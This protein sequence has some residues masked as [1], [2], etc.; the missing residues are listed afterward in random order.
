MAFEPKEWQCGNVLSAEDMNRLEEGV[1]AVTPLIVSAGYDGAG[2]Q[3]SRTWK[4]IND[5]FP[6][7]YIVFDN[8]IK[9]Q[10]ESV[11]PKTGNYYTVNAHDMAFNSPTETGYP[12]T[13]LT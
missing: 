12:T 5:A 2:Y 11:D 9:A 10:V 7:V 6:D 13:V 8:G 1:A 4:Q 3:L